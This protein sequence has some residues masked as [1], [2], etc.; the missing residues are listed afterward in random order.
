MADGVRIRSAIPADAGALAEVHRSTVLTAYAGIFP[1]HAPAPAIED[2]VK[3]WKSAFSDTT[4]R[5]FLAEGPAGPVGTVGVRADPDVPGCGQLRRL[6]VLPEQWGQGTGSALYEA[7]MEDLV[8]SGYG[9][10]S[11]WV[12]EKNPRARAFYERR[13]WALV[14]GQTLKWARLDLIEVRYRIPLPAPVCSD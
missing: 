14:A 10:A 4:F 13:G 8:N 11:L 12:L 9:E 3:D 6:H 7:A 2:L 1:A 5:A